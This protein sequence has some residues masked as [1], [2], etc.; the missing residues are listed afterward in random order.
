MNSNER[1]LEQAGY[2]RWKLSEGLEVGGRNIQPH[3]NLETIERM[4]EIWLSSKTLGKCPCCKKDVKDLS[5]YVETEVDIYHYF[6]FNLA[7]SVGDLCE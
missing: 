3:S 1:E 7:V 2:D 6:C 4:K 5:T